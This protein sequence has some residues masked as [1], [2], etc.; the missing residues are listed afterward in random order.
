MKT[1]DE[2]NAPYIKRN[3]LIRHSLDTMNQNI[4]LRLPMQLKSTLT[5]MLNR[6]QSIANL[7]KTNIELKTTTHTKQVQLPY[8]KH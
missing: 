3:K 4:T 6:H 5:C 2:S 8:T 7:S 1:K